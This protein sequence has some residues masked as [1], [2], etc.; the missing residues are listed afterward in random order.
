M[1]PFLAGLADEDAALLKRAALGVASEWA[2]RDAVVACVAVDHVISLNAVEIVVA[3]AARDRVV[4]TLTGAVGVTALHPVVAVACLDEVQPF[5]SIA[6]DEIVA[7]GSFDD[8]PAGRRVE[9]VGP[10]ISISP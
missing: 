3:V 8:I 10:Q 7:V 9:V 6:V 5:G 1:E 4:A 2:N